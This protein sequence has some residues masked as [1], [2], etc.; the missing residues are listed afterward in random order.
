MLRERLFYHDNSFFR[1]V[2][3]FAGRTAG[4]AF[5]SIPYGFLSL[6]EWSADFEGAYCI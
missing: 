5:G 2:K 6:R 4:K 1:T 3:K